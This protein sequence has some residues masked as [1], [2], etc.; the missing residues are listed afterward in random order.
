MFVCDIDEFFP[1]LIFGLFCDSPQSTLLCD[2]IWFSASCSSESNNKD[3]KFIKKKWNK[4][5]D[6]KKK[7]SML[8][9]KMDSKLQCFHRSIAMK[10]EWNYVTLNWLEKRNCL[11]IFLQANL[12]FLWISHQ[13][14]RTSPSPTDLECLPWFCRDTQG[15][16]NFSKGFGATQPISS[17]VWLSI[18]DIC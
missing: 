10:E 7:I 15:E 3:E 2:S 12:R 1:F 17:S 16:G 5:D 18:Q 6:L 11:P 13:V 8:A 9:F 14:C 4:T